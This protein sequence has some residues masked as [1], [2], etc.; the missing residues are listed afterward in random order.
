MRQK[1]QV[2]AS[3]RLGFPLQAKVASFALALVTA[4]LRQQ[5]C[6]FTKSSPPDGRRESDSR[7]SAIAL[8]RKSAIYLPV[9]TIILK[10]TGS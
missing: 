9:P 7:A 8:V 6:R 2:V 1:V 4:I 3:V 10:L 5:S